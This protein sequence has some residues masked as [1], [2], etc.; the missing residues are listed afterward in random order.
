MNPATEKK[1]QAAADRVHYTQVEAENVRIRGPRA[2]KTWKDYSKTDP[3][4]ASAKRVVKDVVPVVEKLVK[5]SQTVDKDLEK[6]HDASTDPDLVADY[7]DGREYRERTK[8]LLDS[9]RAFEGNA[10]KIVAY[11]K[12]MAGGFYPMMNAP[13]VKSMMKYLDG[14]IE[15][16]NMLKIA[17]NKI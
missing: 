2:I 7:Y 10:A 4:N 9:S 14:F 17:I 8:K 15:Q 1:L 16:F 11:L 6:L 3:S 12:S 5:S 13:D